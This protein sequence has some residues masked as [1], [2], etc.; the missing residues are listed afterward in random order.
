[1][2]ALAIAGPAAA[3]ASAWPDTPMARLEAL[4]MLETFNADLLSHPSATLTLER[5]CSS[6]HLAPTGR[7]IAK[8]DRTIDKP[9]TAEQRQRLRVGGDEKIVYRRVQLLCGDHVLSEADNWYVPS[10]LT[11]E[12]NRLLTE[13]DT[14][15]GRAVLA[16]H[17]HRIL[18]SADLIW[19][20]LPPDW[21]I[22]PALPAAGAGR[23]AI[24]DVVLE[25]RADLLTEADVPFSEVVESYTAAILAR[26]PPGGGR[27][28]SVRR[29]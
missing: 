22:S 24:P 13:T 25:H 26:P 8:L 4:A 11:P 19:H 12:M 3:Q 14:P 10:R 7:I 17:F 20:P 21:D 15:F 6:H 29:T 2:L 1:V 5:W 23:L 28:S 9:A 16:L 18:L 27:P